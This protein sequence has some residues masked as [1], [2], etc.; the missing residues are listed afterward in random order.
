[1]ARPRRIRKPNLIYHVTS[2][3]HN[4]SCLMVDSSF[5][6][7]VLSIILQTQL[8]YRFH[9]LDYQIM[10]D[11]LQLIIK[12]LENEVDISRIMQYLKSQCAQ[13]FNK[14]HHR[15]GAF[16]NDRFRDTIIQYK[17]NPGAYLLMLHIH[18]ARM[19]LQAR[20]ANK[21]GDYEFGGTKFY[22]TPKFKHNR[23]IIT[24]SDVFSI[25]GLTHRQRST[26]FMKLITAYTFS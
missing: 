4:Y 21:A 20:S 23:P 14:I 1:M 7:I 6:R 10:D 24:Y 17:S 5:K 12:T 8:K 13:A 2:H 25:L 19:P 22:L 3:C 9:L 18:F 11:H 15:S 26:R 16:W